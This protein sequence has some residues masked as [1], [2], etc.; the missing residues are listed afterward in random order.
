MFDSAPFTML[1]YHRPVPAKIPKRRSRAGKLLVLFRRW[2]SSSKP[3]IIHTGTDQCFVVAY[4]LRALVHHSI[5]LTYSINHTNRANSKEKKKK[6]NEERPQ[7]DRCLERGLRCEYEPVKPR[8]RRRTVSN[9]EHMGMRPPT[10][11]P[12][13]HLGFHDRLQAL[14]QDSSSGSSILSAS[15]T[16]SLPAIAENWEV[17]SAHSVFSDSASSCGSDTFTDMNSP[18]PP[19]DALDSYARHSAP[20]LGDVK[21]LAMDPLDGFAKDPYDEDMATTREIFAPTSALSRSSSYPD[22]TS[23]FLSPNSG[24]SPYDF[25]VPAFS[26]YTSR[27]SRRGLLDHFCN[28][29]SHLIVFKEDSGNPFRQLVL[30]M[31]QKSPPL[32]NAIYAISSAHLEHRGLHVEERA[33]DLHSKALQGLANLIAHKDEGNRDEVLAVIILLLYYEVCQTKDYIESGINSFIDCAK[34]LLNGAE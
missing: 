27:E 32:L 16:P 10:T 4:R 15:P 8:K 12:G 11:A 21:Q 20:E 26:E 14:R 17:H 2:R 29:L 1:L 7:C 33:L 34:R 18:L 9:P 30:P 5:I 13:Q 3:S 23:A 6:C 28:V 25:S 22:P 24:G 19:F 31:A